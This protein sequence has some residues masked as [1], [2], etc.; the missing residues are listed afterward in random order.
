MLLC[1]FHHQIIIPDEKIK[2]QSTAKYLGIWLDSNLTMSKQINTVCS[3]GYW[4]LRNL[5]RISSK[6]SDITIRTQL[7]HT[8]ILSKINFCSSLYYTINKKEQ[9]KLDKLINSGSKIYL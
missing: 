5:W 6:V 3:Q 9:Y 4:M 8:C 1:L 2:V 7:V